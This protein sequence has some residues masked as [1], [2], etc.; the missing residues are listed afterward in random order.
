MSGFD[1]A[2]DWASRH[3]YYHHSNP[4]KPDGAT[5]FEKSIKRPAVSAAW[6][7]IRGRADGNANEARE[8]IDKYSL[9]AGE[10]N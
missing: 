3:S 8:T 6:N 4:S 2:P 9:A 7:V 5:F 1:L 10:K